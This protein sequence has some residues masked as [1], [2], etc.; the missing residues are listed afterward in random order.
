[1][2]E[3]GDR[4]VLGVS[5]GADSVALFRVFEALREEY[6]LELIVVHIDHGI[7][8]EAREDA[9][10]VEKLCEETGTAFRLFE[11]DI[12]SMAARE[13]RSEEE[14][15]RDYRYRCFFQVMEE[16]GA[17]KLAL[18]H[19]LDDQAETV[20]FHLIRG[21]DLAGVS[22]MS[23][24]SL[25]RLPGGSHEQVRILRPLLGVEKE[26]L[27][28]WLMEEGAGWREDRTNLEDVYARNR[29]RN[30]AMP[31]LKRI[32]SGAARHIAEF[33]RQAAAYESFFRGSVEEYIGIHVL[34]TGRGCETDR[35]LLRE[36]DP[37]LA[38]GILYEML[39]SVGGRRNLSGTH[40]DLV[41]ALL[42]NQSGRRL[43]LPGG[44][45]ATVSYEALRI[46]KKSGR[47]GNGDAAP[48]REDGLAIDLSSG[49]REGVAEPAGGGRIIWKL[50]EMEKM[51]PEEKKEVLFQA[52]NAKNIYTKY[53]DC[54]TI[55][56][57]LH[58]RTPES[59]DYFCLREDGGHKKLSRYFIDCRLPA[60]RRAQTILVASGQEVL[61]VVGMRRCGNY[62]IGEHTETILM[63]TYEEN[64][65]ELSH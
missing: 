49:R 18:A 47:E 55:K 30:Q 36:Q 7:R 23:P 63:L 41:M 4:V 33:A 28:A 21:A 56:G 53:F 15:G 52:G 25:R 5:G 9:L 27:V 50:L 58:V 48:A 3:R 11:A 51:S 35:S 38:R 8:E 16:T 45:E 64:E 61:W 19:H 20:L 32:N 60:E 44:M 22:G 2:L 17:R 31:Q 57:M 13:K 24:V 14:M 26:E 12:P 54:A 42:T 46:R 10:F 43:D 34:F 59:G 1:M 39:C 37:L 29:I 62:R 40:V 65:D 6:G